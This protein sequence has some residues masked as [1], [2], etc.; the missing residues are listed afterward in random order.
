[1]LHSPYDN[2]WSAENLGTESIQELTAPLCDHR[3]WLLVLVIVTGHRTQEVVD[4]THQPKV[5]LSAVQ[6]VM[7]PFDFGIA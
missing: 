2:D 6:K 1:M 4:V 5:K 7:T 3:P